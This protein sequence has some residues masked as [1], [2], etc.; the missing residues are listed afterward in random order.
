MGIRVL[1]EVKVLS[2]THR[3]C[4]P[5][6]CIAA[7]GQAQCGTPQIEDLKMAELDSIGFGHSTT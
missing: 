1:D 3:Y 7:E 2:S 4:V 6:A 5:S